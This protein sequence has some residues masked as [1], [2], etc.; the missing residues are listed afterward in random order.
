LTQAHKEVVSYKL[1][2]LGHLIGIHANQSHR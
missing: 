1:N 2:V